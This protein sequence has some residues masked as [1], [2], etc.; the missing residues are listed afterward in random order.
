MTQHEFDL[1][2]EKYLTGH[3]TP[4]ELDLLNKWTAEQLAKTDF[5]EETEAKIIQ[6]RLWKRLRLKAQIRSS[7]SYSLPAWAIGIA[8]SL[9]LLAGYLGG[10]FAPDQ[11]TA[12]L[13][14]QG[15]ESKNTTAI[16][17]KIVL[18]DG[19]VVVLEKGASLITD[20]NYGKQNRTVFLKGEA[21]FDVK[22]NEKVPFLV[23][24]GSLVTEVL[25]TSFH[26][27]PRTNGKTIEVAVV[28]GRVSVYAAEATQHLNG[29]ILTP[30]Q[31]VLFDT[32]LKTI[33]QG[34][35]AQP[36]LLV[37]DL[38]K[39]N[40]EFEEVALG[41]VV[42]VMQ[43]AFGVEIMV[44]N[45]ILSQCAFTGDLNGLGMYQQLDLIC[46]AINAQYE[47]RG[48]TIFVLGNGCR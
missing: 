13:P 24:S 45:P 23:R 2:S 18:P 33:R 47:I 27:K 43:T 30:N 39:S 34:I 12:E 40:F 28:S 35:V 8:A 20:Q 11:V 19:S 17:Q 3:C 32:E 15:I 21:F 25:G 46:G 44:A 14:K 37:A 36:T 26:I 42:K 38:P 4:D 16:R 31:K 1:L 9:V 10:V 48:T 7:K 22:R 5:L 29:V 6:N 41:E